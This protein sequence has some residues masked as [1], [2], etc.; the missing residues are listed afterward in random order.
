MPKQ[1]TI[2]KVL[3]ALLP[4]IDVA[5]EEMDPKELWTVVEKA[6]KVVQED[7]ELLGVAEADLSCPHCL[8]NL[9]VKIHN[10]EVSI[11]NGDIK[12]LGFED[13]TVVCPANPEHEIPASYIDKI[14]EGLS[15]NTSE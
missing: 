3:T 13:V 15:Q 7:C 1:V 8:A 14:A 12:F 4:D 9:E 6:G 11:V 2:H 10:G 5:L